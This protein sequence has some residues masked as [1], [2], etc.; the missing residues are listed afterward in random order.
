MHVAN[1]DLVDFIPLR[2][3]GPDED[4]GFVFI[5]NEDEEEATAS[6]DQVSQAA[7]HA[8]EQPADLGPDEASSRSRGAA[9]GLSQI[10]RQVFQVDTALLD[11]TLGLSFLGLLGMASA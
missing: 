9:L 1:E 5:A 11:S 2:K 8:Y 7:A 6:D 4:S 3:S 10:L